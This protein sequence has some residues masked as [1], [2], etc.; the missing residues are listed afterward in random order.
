MTNADRPRPV[1]EGV[2]R[3]VQSGGCDIQFQRNFLEQRKVKA[4]VNFIGQ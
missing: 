3:N 1:G 2:C 4:V